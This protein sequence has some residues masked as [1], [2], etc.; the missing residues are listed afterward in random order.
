VIRES[1][2]CLLRRS[3]AGYEGRTDRKLRIAALAA[4]LLLTFAIRHPRS[5]IAGD[6][7]FDQAWLA[8]LTTPAAT[9]GVTT[10]NPAALSFNG[11]NYASSTNGPGTLSSGAFGGSFTIEA[12]FKNTS[13]ICATQ[14]IA[15][16]VGSWGS[17]KGW[18]LTSLGTNAIAEWTNGV[19]FN[20][21]TTTSNLF[22]G[23][24]HHFAWVNVPHAT[25]AYFIDGKKTSQGI[26]TW[27]ITNSNIFIGGFSN[28]VVT[29]GVTNWFGTVSVFRMSGSP[30]YTADFTPSTCLTNDGA[31]R[32]L[33]TF[34]NNTGTVVSDMSTYGCDLF[35]KGNSVPVWTTG[36]CSA[37]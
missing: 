12:V 30:Y 22:D 2:I 14:F 35:L 3:S 8:S 18:M 34:T 6:Q 20:T 25:T 23:A 31:V 7:F 5:A 9:G 16:Q 11:S 29:A 26:P 17:S 28:E 4:I 33:Y 15:G 32:A 13:S 1:R 36:A 24:W 21:C 37:P 19:I 27:S 10:N